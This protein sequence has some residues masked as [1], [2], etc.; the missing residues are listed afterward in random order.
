MIHYA[1]EEWNLHFCAPLRLFIIK[2]Y[3]FEITS[4]SQFEITSKSQY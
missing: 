3:V 2:N 1:M 4:K